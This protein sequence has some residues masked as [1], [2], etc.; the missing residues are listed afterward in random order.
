[1]TNIQQETVIKVLAN[2]CG[3]H[4]YPEFCYFDAGSSL[5]FGYTS[6]KNRDLM[7]S[8]FTLKTNFVKLSAK[9][10]FLNQS[11]RSVREVRRFLKKIFCDRQLKTLPPLELG[12]T[13][14]LIK[15]V[16]NLINLR[17]CFE[18]Q[19]GRAVA[20]ICFSKPRWGLAL[21][22]DNIA[23]RGEN[24]IFKL[25]QCENL[26]DKHVS[27]VLN[28][29]EQMV[30]PLIT[31][32]AAGYQILVDHLKMDFMSNIYNQ[33]VG[34]KKNFQLK[35]GDIVLYEVAEP[36]LG[37]V[38]ATFAQII[39]SYGQYYNIKVSS[40]NGLNKLKQI[41]RRYL[42]FIHRPATSRPGGGECGESA[43][44]EVQSKHAPHT[45]LHVSIISQNCNVTLHSASP[46]QLPPIGAVISW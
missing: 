6:K 41:H 3:E 35:E 34:H 5:N 46:G 18:T 29:L 11:E 27:Q 45:S 7:E 28:E 23:E 2:H 36:H 32:C 44:E 37:Q 25:S 13:L 22:K 42:I 8:L 1:M 31:S 26:S 30:F 10:Q 17:P 15:S 38:K 9:H 21:S 33:Q 24:L 19:D 40:R 14:M 43:G 4:G 16:E 39:K 20:P 12:E